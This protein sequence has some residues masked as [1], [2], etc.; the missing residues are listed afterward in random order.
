MRS[1]SFISLFWKQKKKKFIIDHV[2]TFSSTS[3]VYLFHRW[4]WI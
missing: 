4:G 2:S 1:F 3:V